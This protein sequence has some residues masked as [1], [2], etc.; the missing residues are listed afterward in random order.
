MHFMIR[1]KTL[2]FKV[3]AVNHS[4]GV[5]LSDGNDYYINKSSCGN[6][7]VRYRIVDSKL[8][9][10]IEGKIYIDVEEI[11]ANNNVCS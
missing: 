1:K 4:V 5:L 9:K 2:L 7:E 6:F 10:P 3:S 8:V 11:G